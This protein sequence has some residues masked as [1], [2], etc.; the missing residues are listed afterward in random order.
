MKKFIFF[1]ISVFIFSFQSYCQL[2][3]TAL[4]DYPQPR[5]APYAFMVGDRFF[6]GGGA[7]QA[8]P[9]LATN[10]L[11]EYNFQTDTWEARASLPTG[12]TMYDS[13]MFVINGEAYTTCGQLVPTSGGYMTTLYQYDPSQDKWTAKAPFPGT[14]RYTSYMFSIGN[15]GYLGMGDGSYGYV[16]DF[17]RYDPDADAWTQIDSFPGA[18]RQ[19]GITFA[20]NGMAYVGLGASTAGFT[21]DMYRYDTASGHWTQ[22]ASF[23][24]SPR[25]AST[26]ITI[27]NVAYIIGGENSSYN[28]LSDIWSYTPATNSWALVDSFSGLRLTE[29]VSG[30]NGS[31]AVAGTGRDSSSGYSNKLYKTGNPTG[32]NDVQS[33]KPKIWCYADQLHINFNQP[34]SYSATLSLYDIDGRQVLNT[35]LVKGQASF[36]ADLGQDSHG[37][38]FYSIEGNSITEK[39]TGKVIT[40]Q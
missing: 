24:G 2:T 18:A 39:Y 7:Y 31:F 28:P 3:W 19:T 25:A 33:N 6:L 17:W 15:Y 40:G 26:A 10:D 9:I 34:L 29:I 4:T 5:Y 13:R 16:N 37:M 8:S 1:F 30:D 35:S 36:K 38:Y 27:N 20:I 21:T 11:M 12:I 23:P 14:P 32:I 22:M